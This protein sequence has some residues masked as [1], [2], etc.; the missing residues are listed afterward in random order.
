M[1]ALDILG[2]VAASF[3]MASA[4]PQLLRIY[5]TRSSAGVSLSLFQLNAGATGAWAMHGLM[6]GV[7][8]MQYPNLILT[9]SSL[10]VCVLVLRDRRAPLLPA[11][12]LP[13]LISVALF[14]TDLLFGPLAFGFIV[15][16]PFVVGQVSQLRTMLRSTDLSGVSLPFLSI[17]VLVQGLWLTWG[18]LYGETSI[19]VCATLL[20]TLSLA[21]LVYF[22]HRVLAGTI[23]VDP[24]H[25]PSVTAVDTA[26]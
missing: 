19:T 21:N 17:A 20:G 15:A 5:R 16:A 13:P 25:A 11:L 9:I 10:A 7:P 4:L 6:V 22:L 23:T 14:G 8:Q 3:G 26:S 18:I 2:W 24:V 12:L 1:T